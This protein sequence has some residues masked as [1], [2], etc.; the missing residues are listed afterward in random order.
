MSE[1]I[2]IGRDELF[3]KGVDEALARSRALQ[4]RAA[5][6]QQPISPLRR[7]WNNSLFYL[8]LAALLGA[9]LVYAFL[10]PKIDDY[11]R[12]AGQISLFNGDPFLTEGDAIS[13]TVN[14]TEVIIVEGVTE[15][16]PGPEDEAALS[17]EE[18]DTGV[19]IEAVGYTSEGAGASMVATALRPVSPGYANGVRDHQ[20]SELDW[21]LMLLFP[22]T[23]VAVAFFLLLAEGLSTRNWSRMVSRTIVGSF[24]A[25]VLSFAGMVP[26]GVIFQFFDPLAL[27]GTPEDAFFVNPEAVAPWAFLGMMALRSAAWAVIGAALGLGM[28]IARTTKKQLRNSVVGGAMGGAVGGMFFDPIDRFIPQSAFADAGLSRLIGLLAVGLMVGLFVALVERLSREAWLRVRT[29]PLAGKSFVLYKTPTVIGSSP[30]ADIYLFKDAEIDGRHA[31]I[32]RVGNAYELEDD[33]SRAGTRIAGRQV[34][35]ARLTSGDQ[36][37]LGGTVLEFEERQSHDR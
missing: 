21:P 17:F 31:I 6:P 16:L 15:L 25:L 2:D 9:L 13:L 27:A 19:T 28:N 7:L 1:R 36:L 32:H 30:D 22:L 4:G 23:G 10:E 3:S 14:T 33:G 5:P 12:V 26:A 11:A 34:R 35:R 8:P 37:V 20:Q 24:L 29:G 18:L